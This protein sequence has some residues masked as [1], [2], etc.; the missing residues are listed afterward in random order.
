MYGIYILW[1]FD[2][3]FN[4]FYFSDFMTLSTV[5]IQSNGQ[6]GKHSNPNSLVMPA[7]QRTDDTQRLVLPVSKTTR[8][9]K[10]S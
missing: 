6:A 7:L 2:M 4:I 9:S 10:G 8:A 3:F 1:I 5:I